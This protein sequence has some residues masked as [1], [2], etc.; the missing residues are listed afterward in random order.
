MNLTR[1]TLIATVLAA[2]LCFAGTN[3]TSPATLTSKT[4]ETLFEDGIEASR[5]GDYTDAAGAFGESLRLS[6]SSGALLNLGVTQWRRGRAGDAVLAWEQALWLDPFNADAR[7]NLDFARNV[8]QI[9]PPRL[10]WHEAVST[11][12][13]SGLW[14]W[15]AVA[16]LCVVLFM[17]TLP[18]VFRWRKTGW[19]QALAAL[20]LGV[21][22]LS[23]PAN[24]GVIS[25][26]RTGFV[27]E[28]NTPLF[29][30]P[31]EDA[32]STTTLAAGEP[33]RLVRMRGEF[34]LIRT[35]YGRGWVAAKRFGLICPQ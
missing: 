32:E 5:L 26:A 13:P 3:E 11:R 12:L 18:P 22:L 14:A 8:A 16:S 4:A 1:A 7:N 25:R 34:V 27:L 23:I 21:F 15:M 9:E 6:P 30:T 29:L 33:A 17:I 31:T 24:I 20:G 2:G 28:K 35:Q 19:H 10:A